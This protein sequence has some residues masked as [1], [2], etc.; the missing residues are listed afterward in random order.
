MTSPFKITQLQGI[1][2]VCHPNL[3]LIYNTS[4]GFGLNL[5]EFEY[6]SDVEYS[7]ISA[8]QT[9]LVANQFNI[10]V[11]VEVLLAIV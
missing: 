6:L 9:H 1:D 3:S 2:L 8:C 4:F 11:F 5:N 7:K 10:F